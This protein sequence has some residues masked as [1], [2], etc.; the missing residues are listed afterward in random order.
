MVFSWCRYLS[1]EA[2]SNPNHINHHKYTGIISFED[3]V[4]D[5]LKDSN[6][7]ITLARNMGYS[8]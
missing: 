6:H 1:C 3:F 5:H 7:R 2:L 8:E 4:L